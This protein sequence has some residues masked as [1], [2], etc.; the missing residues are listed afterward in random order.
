MDAESLVLAVLD[1]LPNQEVR[2]KKRLQKL[3]YFV[4]QAGTDSTARFYLHDFGP[5]SSDV[6]G[7]TDLLSFVGTISEKEAQFVRTKRYYKVYRLTDPEVVTE[8]LPAK[9]L[10]TLHKLND[11]TTIELEIASTIRYF[12]SNGYSLEDAI[13]ATT[14]LKP[15]KSQPTIIQRAKEALLKVGL[16]EG[17]GTDQMPSSRPHR[18]QEIPW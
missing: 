15:S 4:T 5:F 3:A 12:I 17:G 1:A 7:A 16:Y 8:R 18:V 10:D 11:Y 6:A 13:R 14:E 2:G 9:A